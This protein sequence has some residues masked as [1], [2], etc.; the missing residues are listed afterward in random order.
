V[1]GWLRGKRGLLCAVGS[2][3]TSGHVG[4]AAPVLTA[5]STLHLLVLGR[6]RWVALLPIGIVVSVRVCPEWRSEELE[7]LHR[8]LRSST[9]IEVLFGLTCVL[10][11]VE[12]D[13][14]RAHHICIFLL[15]TF[16][17]RLLTS[18]REI[19]QVPLFLS[20]LVAWRPGPRSR[21]VCNRGRHHFD[22]VPGR[23]AV[24]A[25][26]EAHKMHSALQ[27]CNRRS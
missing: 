20:T 9:N 10:R 24:A 18:R 13:R 25:G 4:C 16:F 2:V 27:A 21:P 3:W 19:L 14:G 11:T 26:L 6:V 22:V 12:T 17:L 15:I 8:A 7:E 5:V 1:R 23:R